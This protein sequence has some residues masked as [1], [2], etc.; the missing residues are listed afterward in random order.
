MYIV[1]KIAALV[2]FISIKPYGRSGVG[3]TK[4]PDKG[5]MYVIIESKN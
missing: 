3:E 4:T 5:L 2:G 1:K